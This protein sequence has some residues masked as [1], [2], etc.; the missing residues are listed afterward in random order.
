MEEPYSNKSSFP[1]AWVMNSS[2]YKLLIYEYTFYLSG[3]AEIWWGVLADIP[4]SDYN[5]V[6]TDFEGERDDVQKESPI[7]QE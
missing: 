2:N 6:R 1:G 4:N 5:L 7:V 3:I